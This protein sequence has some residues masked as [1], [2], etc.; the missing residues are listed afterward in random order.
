AVPSKKIPDL[1][2]RISTRYVT[3]KSNGETFQAFCQRI[4]K[5]ALKDMMDGFTFVPTHDVDRSV[6]SDWGDPRQYTIG[7][8]GT[9]E[10]AGEVVS[11]AQFGFMAAESDAFEAQLLLD[12][13]KY[14]E[15]DQKAYQAMLKAARTLVQLQWA[16]APDDPN[17]IVS[18]FRTRFVETKIFWDT[19]HAAQFSNYL[20]NRHEGADARY[21]KDTAHKLVEEANLFIDA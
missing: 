14:Q 11:L 2:D 17:V 9:G 3:E 18:E 16:D 21:T 15:A 19:Y 20:F 4:G 7:D 1:I 6:Y 12:D 13:E 5:K 10:C 8:M